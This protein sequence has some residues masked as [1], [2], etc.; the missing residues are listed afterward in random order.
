LSTSSKAKGFGV[1]Q[2]QPEQRPVKGQEVHKTTLSLFCVQMLA[3]LTLRGIACLFWRH[4]WFF[5]NTTLKTPS[6]GSGILSPADCSIYY[7]LNGPGTGGSNL[8]TGLF[9]PM[10]SALKG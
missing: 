5:R 6:E 4:V 2:F 3:F 1:E 10:V 8:C 9:T 7:V